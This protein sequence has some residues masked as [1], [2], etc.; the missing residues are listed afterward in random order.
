MTTRSNSQLTEDLIKA[1]EKVA[2]LRRL[3]SAEKVAHNATKTI[4]TQEEVKTKS[5]TDK[6]RSALST[7]TFLY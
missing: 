3:L 4:L 7:Q 5:D 1:N 2:K 6:F